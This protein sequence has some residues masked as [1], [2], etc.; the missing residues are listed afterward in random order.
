MHGLQ[1]TFTGGVGG[2][3]LANMVRHVLLMPPS[4]LRVGMPLA[5]LSNAVRHADGAIPGAACGAQVAAAME[6]NTFEQE[7]LGGALLRFYWYYGHQLDLKCSIVTGEHM[8]TSV[9]WG[10]SAPGWL[11]HHPSQLSINDPA[12]PD[13]DLG[14]KAYRFGLVRQ[15]LRA[16]YA[17]LMARVRESERKA[18]DSAS[19][20]NFLSLVLPKWQAGRSSG[21]ARRHQ[22]DLVRIARRRR[23]EEQR[24][25]LTTAQ[26]QGG[27][28]TD[29]LWSHPQPP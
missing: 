21:R 3:L 20:A 8:E 2:Y 10:P 9:A 13:S 14:A 7:D 19:S 25:A 22:K 18:P 4:P 26:L 6:R 12:K 24:L 11:G 27:S 17:K 16:T 23:V 5:G 29:P 1:N 15:L 28:R